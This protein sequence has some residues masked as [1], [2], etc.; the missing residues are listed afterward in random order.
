MSQQISVEDWMGSPP[1]EVLRNL[2]GR[3]LNICVGGEVGPEAT[4]FG[5]FF[6][7][8][9]VVY[10]QPIAAQDEVFACGRCASEARYRIA[11]EWEAGYESDDGNEV[12]EHCIDGI[13]TEGAEAIPFGTEP[14]TDITY[15]VT[16]KTDLYPE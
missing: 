1:E 15:E 3:V 12:C 11:V 2:T 5:E 8:A 13:L 16:V 4:P 14:G 10:V 7:F 9:R 6:R